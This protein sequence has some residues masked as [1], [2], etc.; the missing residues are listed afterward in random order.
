MD[1]NRA[2]RSRQE[3]HFDLGGEAGGEAHERM[4]DAALNASN[5][6]LVVAAAS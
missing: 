5:D 1:D 6:M 2:L 4:D 3:Y